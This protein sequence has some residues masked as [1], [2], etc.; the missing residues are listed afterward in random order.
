MAP[1]LIEK[2]AEFVFVELSES[3]MAETREHIAACADCRTRVEHFQKTHAM[4][5]ASP[6]LDL[7]RNIVFEL[8]K[9]SLNRFRWLTPAAAAALFVVVIAL[10]GVIHVRWRDSQLTI[11]F[12]QIIPPAENNQ[13]ALAAEIQRLQ[14]HLAYLEARQQSV[15]RDAI[16]TASRIQLIARAQR[17]PAGD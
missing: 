4:L 6:D 12:G 9:P 8:E 7:P 15:E 1:H 2:L 14:G 10:A 3:E 11:A 13:T 5:R 16:A 17:S